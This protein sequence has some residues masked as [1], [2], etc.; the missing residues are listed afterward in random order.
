M[1][2]ERIEKLIIEYVLALKQ[3]DAD[4]CECADHLDEV[5][6]MQMQRFDRWPKLSEVAYSIID[7][8]TRAFEVTFTVTQIPSILNDEVGNIM[9]DCFKLSDLTCAAYHAARRLASADKAR[10]GMYRRQLQQLYLA[11]QVYI[12]YA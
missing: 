10:Q 9:C 1:I 12:Y 5:M 4:T 2:D 11:I 7:I 3:G 8:V 6:A